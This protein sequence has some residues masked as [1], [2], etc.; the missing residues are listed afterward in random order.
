MKFWDENFLNKR[1]KEWLDSIYK[2]QYYDG[3]IWRDA[4]I[5]EKKIEGNTLKILS[6]T[7]DN[8]SLTITRVRLLDTGGNIAGQI[9]ES[10]KKLSTQGVITLWEFPLYEIES[11]D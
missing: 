8:A 3:E 9:S 11:T 10:I 4:A 7:T 2:I 1:R 6:V 5:T